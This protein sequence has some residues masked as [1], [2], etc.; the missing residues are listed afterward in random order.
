VRLHAV[1]LELDGDGLGRLVDRHLDVPGQREGSHAH[2]LVCPLDANVPGRSV[3]L[4]HGDRDVPEPHEA[5]QRGDLARPAV[6]LA[7][8]KALLDAREH[9]GGGLLVDAV[10]LDVTDE[11]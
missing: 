5:R 11:H 2:E 4:R 9:E 10:A 6:R 7:E 1:E 8:P 3:E